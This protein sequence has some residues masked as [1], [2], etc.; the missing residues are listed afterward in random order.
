[1]DSS[2]AVNT[3]LED[4]VEILKLHLGRIRDQPSTLSTKSIIVLDDLGLQEG[5]E[6]LIDALAT[7]IDKKEKLIASFFFIITTQSVL[8]TSRSA[9]VTTCEI[10][11]FE[12]DDLTEMLSSVLKTKNIDYEDIDINKAVT[13]IKERS[14]LLPLKCVPVV[15]GFSGERVSICLHDLVK[16]YIYCNYVH[17]S[18]MVV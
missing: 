15:R 14:S 1:M 5:R 11:E 18:I 16:Q 17:R 3:Q 8:K 13:R 7:W 10:K 2:H 9:S 4:P 12:E 6:K